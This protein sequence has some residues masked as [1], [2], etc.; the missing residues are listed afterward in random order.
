MT[1]CILHSTPCGD[2]VEEKFEGGLSKPRKVHFK[3]K[4]KLSQKAVYWI[5]LARAQEKGLQFWRTRSR[6]IVVYDSLPLD[7][8]ERVMSEHGEKTLHQ[9]LSTPRQA[10]QE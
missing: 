2:E 6:A 10:S 8:I 4:W 7:C 9:R 3:T 5:P 1:N